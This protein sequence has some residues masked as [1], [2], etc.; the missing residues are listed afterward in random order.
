[1]AV[2][3]SSPSRSMRPASRRMGWGRRRRPCFADPGP[4]GCQQQAG[5]RRDAT[6]HAAKAR[7]VRQQL[8]RQRPQRRRPG[9]H[10]A[11]HD[12]AAGQ[13]LALQAVAQHGL[14][15]DGAGCQSQ[16]LDEAP[17]QQRLE[18]WRPGGAQ[19]ARQACAQAGQQR[20]SPAPGVAQPAPQQHAS[21][22]AQE[23]DAHDGL[24][25]GPRPAASGGPGRAARARGWFP[26]LAA[27]PAGR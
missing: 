24:R 13:C 17:G 6:Q 20:R 26:P 11:Q 5:Q 12:E 1:M 9:Q 19:G 27:G 18:S 15:G 25:Q 7:L 14:R 2:H 10:G 21:G 23:V 16:R 3:S 8:A 22:E 4:S